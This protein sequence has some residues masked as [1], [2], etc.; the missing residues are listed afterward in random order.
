MIA[1]AR[2]QSVADYLDFAAHSRRLSDHTLAGYAR[3]L[4]ALVAGLQTTT[5][6]AASTDDIRRVAARLR[7]RGLSPRSISRTLSAWRGYYGWLGN[8][9]GLA[10][11][12]CAGVRAPKSDRGLPKALSPDITKRLLDRSP[13]DDLESRDR[14]MFELLY[15]SGLRLAELHG[16]GWRDGL[17]A[18]REGEITVLGKGGK[19]R[20]VPVGSAARSALDAWLTIRSRIANEAEQ[21]LFV[22]ARGNRLSMRAIQLRLERW[23]VRSGLGVSVHPHMLRHSFATHVLQ[24][25]SDLRAVQDMLGHASI[26]T[27]QV[28]TSLDFQHLSRIY[29]AAHPRARRKVSGGGQ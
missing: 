15:S 22:S 25:S 10:V 23:A 16:L 18:I 28:Y 29:D 1:P 27:T 6:E 19:R 17:Q 24:S 21:G 20:T 12:P 7:V 9:R 2:P 8:N 11:D 5:P 4:D 13:E 3:D 26:S 14:A